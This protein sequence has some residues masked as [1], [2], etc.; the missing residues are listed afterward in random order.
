MVFEGRTGCDDEMLHLAD[1]L[2]R[3]ISHQSTFTKPPLVFWTKGV[4]GISTQ[5]MQY[6][7]SWYHLPSCRAQRLVRAD[8]LLQTFMSDILSAT[9][10]VDGGLSFGPPDGAPSGFGFGAALLEVEFL[11]SSF[12]Y[13][14]NSGLPGMYFRRGRGTSIPYNGQHSNEQIGK[15]P[16]VFSLVIF[17]YAAECSLSGT[18]C[19]IQSMGVGFPRIDSAF[20]LS[21]P[22]FQLSCLVVGAI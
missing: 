12:V 20:F 14:R 6:R 22:N 2:R 17:Q 8:N 11:G 21:V 15:L 19:T 4:P 13:G 5:H 1:S 10:L 9:L 16:Y 7:L 18:Q 3:R